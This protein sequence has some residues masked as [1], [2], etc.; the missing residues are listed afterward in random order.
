MDVER[1][2]GAAA[3]ADDRV[4]AGAGQRTPGGLPVRRSLREDAVEHGWRHVP[5][6]GL[7]VC[8][9]TSSLGV[10]RTANYFSGSLRLRREPVAKLACSMACSCCTSSAL[11]R[12][13]SGSVVGHPA[14]R[15]GEV[16][17]RR[18]LARRGDGRRNYLRH[19][20]GGLA[21]KPPDEK[22]S[23]LRREQLLLVG[24]GGCMRRL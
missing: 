12:S 20:R 4:A 16:A 13:G 24:S 10:V 11:R 1:S 3:I 23:G 5:M 18:E 8:K 15:S 7:I 21:G 19:R 2:A 9:R 17:V 22:R 6:D 14:L